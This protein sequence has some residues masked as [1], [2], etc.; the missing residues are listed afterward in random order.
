[1][2]FRVGA[3]HSQE[4]DDVIE[5]VNGIAFSNPGD[6]IVSNGYSNNVNTLDELHE[7][8]DIEMIPYN[9]NKSNPQRN[10]MGNI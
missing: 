7:Q 1:M 3:E 8:T 4:T 2:I 10:N 9:N 6:K 5:G